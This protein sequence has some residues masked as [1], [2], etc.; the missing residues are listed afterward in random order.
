MFYIEYMGC[1]TG[2]AESEKKM[3]Q[4]F[5]NQI[6]RAKVNPSQFPNAAAGMNAFYNGVAKSDCPHEVGSHAAAIWGAGF[7]RAEQDFCNSDASVDE[8]GCAEYGRRFA[9]V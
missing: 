5:N 2:A 6:E 8:D 1:V 7:D 3:N 4:A 9:P